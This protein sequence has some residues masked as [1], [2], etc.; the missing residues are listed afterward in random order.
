M[1]D[2]A[3]RFGCSMGLRLQRIE[4]CECDT[5]IN[6][7]IFIRQCSFSKQQMRNVAGCQERQ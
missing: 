1:I 5:S 2:T 4:W 6:Q 3:M 7:S